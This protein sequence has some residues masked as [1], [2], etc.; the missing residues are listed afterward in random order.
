MSIE[1]D[2]LEKEAVQYWNKGVAEDWKNWPKHMDLLKKLG[3]TFAFDDVTGAYHLQTEQDGGCGIVIYPYLSDEYGWSVGCIINHEWKHVY[4]LNDFEQF[5]S[6]LIQVR[7]LFPFCIE[8]DKQKS[9]GESS[10]AS[11]INL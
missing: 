3:C 10:E 8:Q 5:K 1:T 2:N 7:T 6:K 11:E 9:P 4:K